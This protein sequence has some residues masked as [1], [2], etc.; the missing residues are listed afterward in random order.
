MTNFVVHGAT[1]AQG[2]PVMSALDR[3]G[4]RVIGLAR[5]AAGAVVR[6]DLDE[7]DVP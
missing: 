4:H 5:D 7:P 1:G 2:R 3:A 6:A